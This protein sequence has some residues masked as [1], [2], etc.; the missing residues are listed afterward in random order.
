MSL[1]EIGAK[2]AG[3]PHRKW[4]TLSTTGGRTRA[5]GYTFRS[6]IITYNI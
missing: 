2:L 6:I 5:S 4:L 1:G 3:S